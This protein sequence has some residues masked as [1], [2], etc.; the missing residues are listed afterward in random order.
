[1]KLKGIID[2]D[3]VNYKKPCMTLE[4]PI[5]KGFKC[6]KLNN[7]RVCQNGALASEPDVEINSIDLIERYIRNPITEAIC[8]QGLEPLDSF[9]ELLA[10]INKLRNMYNCYDEIVIYTGYNKDEIKFELSELQKYSNIIIKFGRFLLNRPSKFDEVLGVTLA[11]DN[12]CA[13][14]IS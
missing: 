7:K 12:Q 10:F 2:E 3:F 4:F 6:D 8:C 11:S 1:M 13:E 9:P 5:C 14:K